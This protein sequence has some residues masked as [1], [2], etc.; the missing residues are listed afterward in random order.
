MLGGRVESLL[1]ITCSASSFTAIWWL[2]FFC[3]NSLLHHDLERPG[4]RCERKS[5][6][7]NDLC[8]LVCIDRLCYD[9]CHIVSLRIRHL[10][11]SQQESI[12]WMVNFA[13][14][15]VIASKGTF[16]IVYQRSMTSP[17]DTRCV[18]PYP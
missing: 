1:P 17:G 16:H 8:Q 4:P 3:Y 12:F 15:R 18:T 11:N 9:V 5:F 10:L 13:L 14:L 6:D 7:T 2:G